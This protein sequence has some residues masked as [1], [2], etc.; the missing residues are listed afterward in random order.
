ML[1][2]PHQGLESTGLTASGKQVLW[3]A[4][5]TLPVLASALATTHQDVISSLVAAP[6]IEEDFIAKY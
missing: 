6:L 1:S 2:G 3:F 4:S 5:Y